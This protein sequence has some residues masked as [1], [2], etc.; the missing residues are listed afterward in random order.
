MNREKLT[1]TKS[2]AK[3][4]AQ[5]DT[6]DFVTIQNDITGTSRWSVF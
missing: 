3:D 4:I 6:H 2:E 1:F 5:E